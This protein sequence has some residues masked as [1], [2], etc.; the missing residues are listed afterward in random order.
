MDYYTIFAQQVH[1]RKSV[2][3]ARLE[4]LRR[5]GAHTLFLGFEGGSALKLAATPDMPYLTMVDP[6]Y[7][8]HRNAPPWHQNRFEHRALTEIHITPGDRVLT[9]TFDSGSRL[10]F[11]MTGRHANIIIVD[12][13]GTIIS[14]LRQVTGK[15]STIRQVAA[16][17]P[18]EPP[19]RREYP[20]L[21]GDSADLTRRLMAEDG[22]VAQA[23]AS[24]ISCGSRYFALETCARASILPTAAVLDLAPEHLSR[25]FAEAAKL[26]S[27][28]RSGGRGGSLI[29]RKDGLPQDVF[30]LPMSVEGLAVKFFEDLNEAVAVYA[31]EREIELEIRS[32]RAGITSALAAEEKRIRS[33]IVKVEH[34]CG[35]EAEPENLDQLANTLLANLHR[36][37]RGAATITLENVFTGEPVAIALDPTLT[38]AENAERL[39]RR[40]KKL[41]SA[42]GVARRR[43]ADM[44]ARLAQIVRDRAEADSV[45]DIRDL[46]KLSARHVHLQQAHG[47]TEEGEPLF[48]RRFISVSGLDIIVGRSDEENDALIRW[49]RKTDLWLH[50]QSIP[51]SHVILRAPGKQAPDRKSIEQAAAIA[52]HFS[53]GR[54]SGIVPVAVTPVKYVVKRKGMAPGKVIYSREEVIF[55]EPWKG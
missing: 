15:E 42:T 21:R 45:T 55:V 6:D 9:F 51:G 25:L 50:A 40:A 46:R 12:T 27:E 1:L 8:P 30:P 19:P 18:Y 35:D 37:T 49:A 39:F 32:L 54:T 20:D 7:I 14:A 41:R 2:T 11:E 17:I 26:D 16:G 52:A 29:Y 36:L 34:E 5:A 28:I 53:K 22:A 24:S 13:T 3:G 43:L 4:I 33:T 31:R 47:R 10:V 48:P 44:L 38:G 23:L